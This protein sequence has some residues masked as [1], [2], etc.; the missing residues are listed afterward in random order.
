[1]QSSALFCRVSIIASA[2]SAVLFHQTPST[3]FNHVASVL[4][5]HS[6]PEPDE[7]SV[8]FHLLFESHMLRNHPVPFQSQLICS[9]HIGAPTC[10]RHG[11]SR[12]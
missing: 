10:S 5:S 7:P 11:D 9:G 2:W 8:L 4:H 6:R 12:S 3:P 1:M